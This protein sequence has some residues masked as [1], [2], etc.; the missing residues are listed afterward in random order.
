M[1][2]RFILWRSK[3]LHHWFRWR[4]DS[5]RRKGAFHRAARWNATGRGH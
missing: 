1:K 3:L 2:T 5:A 4:L